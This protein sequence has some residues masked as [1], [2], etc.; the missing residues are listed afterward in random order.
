MRG[1]RDQRQRR[2]VEDHVFRGED[3]GQHIDDERRRELLQVE[4]QAA[5]KHG[6]GNLLGVGGRQHEL[7]VRRRLLQRLQ[8]RIERGLRQ[9]VHF[10]DQVD[11]EAPDR[12][13]VA[14][15]VEHFAHVVD[16]GV[17]R[18]IE[19]QQIYEAA[20]VD[21]HAGGAGA[22]RL[23]GDAVGDAVE[24]FREDARDRRLA[25]AAR[26]GEKICVM[27]PVAAQRIGQRG[28]H[29]LL[30]DQLPEGLRP[31]LAGECLVAHRS[32]QALICASPIKHEADMANKTKRVA[33]RSPGTCSE[34]LWLLPSGPDQVH[35]AAMRGDPPLI[36]CA[37]GAEWGL[38]AIGVTAA[39]SASL[40]RGEFRRSEGAAVVCRYNRPHRRSQCRRR[41][42]HSIEIASFAPP[43]PCAVG[44]C[45]RGGHRT[46]PDRSQSR[47]PCRCPTRSGSSSS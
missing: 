9:H 31:P 44:S 20:G 47:N 13:H 28:H 25:D 3:G 24:A 27:K 12:R 7:D 23:G 38:S 10:V 21:V 42:R 22:A 46:L 19:L 29:V 1:A 26:A 34:S 18:G 32:D 41:Q 4:L 33:S 40:G 43:R 30:A 45:P 14:R 2:R 15:V 8:H 37:C 6:D 36:G 39:S 5:R 35:D 17:G 11:L 16:A